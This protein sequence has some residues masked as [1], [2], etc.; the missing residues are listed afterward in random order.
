MAAAV[1][2]AGR[3]ASGWPG[4]RPGE[5]GEISAARG[6]GQ[7]RRRREAAPVGRARRKPRHLVDGDRR[8]ACS[9]RPRRG[10]VVV[11][12]QP[13]RTRVHPGVSQPHRNRP[14]SAR[15]RLGRNHMRAEAMAAQTTSG[16]WRGS[17]RCR[18]GSVATMAPI[19]GS[20]IWLVMRDHRHR[21]ARA[22]AAPSASGAPAGPDRRMRSP[23]PG[24][25]P[26]PPGRRIR[27]MS[28]LSRNSRSGRSGSA[29][30][31]PTRGSACAADSAGR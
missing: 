4:A 31:C 16:L 19:A 11:F 17:T 30:R 27:R 26:R 28:R 29:R 23:E 9:A 10:I 15:C 14:R 22:A 5:N 13:L 3:T 2:T 21:P 20:S 6:G 18:R 7:M 1:C 8:P 25:S 12:H 24:R